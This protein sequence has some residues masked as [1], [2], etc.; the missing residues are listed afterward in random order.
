M[1][2]RLIE[3]KGN[4][5]A[6]YYDA[7]S[8]LFESAIGLRSDAYREIL[9]VRDGTGNIRGN[10]RDPNRF[11]WFRSRSFGL[12][13]V[14]QY[15]TAS[16]SYNRI[17]G[18][19]ASGPV[20][21]EYSEFDFRTASARAMDKLYQELTSGSNLAVD[22]F[23]GKETLRMI[24]NV[25]KLRQNILEFWTELVFP[26]STTTYVRGR[27]GTYIRPRTVTQG[28]KRLDYATQKWME[29]RY[30][31]SPLVHSI[32]DFVKA[33][34]ARAESSLRRFVTRG[35]EV[36]GAST[37]SGHGTFDSPYVYVTW[38][39]SMR[40]RLDVTLFQEGGVVLQDFTSLNPALIAWEL[41]PLSFVF[42][43]VYN[44][45]G[46]MQAIEN[47]LRFAKDFRSG[48]ETLTMLR[49]VSIVVNGSSPNV[50]GGYTRIYGTSKYE[51]RLLNRSVLLGLPSPDLVPRFNPNLN[52]K[53]ALDACALLH[54]F[55]GIPSRRIN[56][57]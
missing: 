51:Q 48:C 17:S 38:S 12:N 22:I 23:E 42:D 36:Q 40:S 41:A 45:G 8:G 50:D 54:S 37:R 24:R 57:V 18:F 46:W 14:T 55:R 1:Q 31:W 34:K 21:W 49:E 5:S 3:L 30:G 33:L 56:G 26:S 20:G 16:G 53:R 28:Q 44:V 6:E 15:T 27:K 7:A 39:Q 52:A 19:I 4:F 25:T 29:F 13:G 32:Y 35:K 43:W 2:P 47:Y 10:H 11:H 9:E